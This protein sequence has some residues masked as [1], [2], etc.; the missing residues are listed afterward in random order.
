MEPQRLPSATH[1]PAGRPWDDA[2]FGAVGAGVALLDAAG[3]FARANRAFEELTGLSSADLEGSAAPFAFWWPDD[4]E[5]WERAIGSA[6]AG[7]CVT[8]HARIRAG[9]ATPVGVHVTAAPIAPGDGGPAAVVVTLV[10]L[11]TEAS[12]HQAIGDFTALVE[13]SPDAIVRFGRD[14][15]ISYMNRAAERNSGVPRESVVGVPLEA[16][17]ARDARYEECVEDVVRTGRPGEAEFLYH[18]VTGHEMWVRTRFLPEF[19]G[20]GGVRGVVTLAQNVTARKRVELELE[21]LLELNT[22]GVR[23]EAAI[24]G[25]AEMVA[26]GDDFTRVCEAV[27]RQVVELL[28]ADQAWVSRYEDDGEDFVGGSAADV[29]SAV[30]PGEPVEV[31]VNVEGAPWGVLRATVGDGITPEARDVLRTLADLVAT[32]CVNARTL[33]ELARIAHSDPLTGLPNRRAFF[34]HLEAEIERAHRFGDEL[35]LAMIDLDH[36]KQ[37]ND[38]FGHQRGDD[39][40]CHIG[41]RLRTTVRRGEVLARIGGEEFAWVLPRVDRDAALG[42]LERARQAVAAEPVEG[43]GVITVSAGVASLRPGDTSKSLMGRADDALYRAKEAGR[44][45]VVTEQPAS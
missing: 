18:S 35:T 45:R 21:R 23:R 10:P 22:R 14:G 5:R 25:I 32:A 11:P 12:N 1:V 9:Q 43:V 13:D 20:V 40:L 33:G 15:R 41:A 7:R 34:E 28:G 44:D 2:L 38:R 27:S 39:A 42:V 16:L 4:I 26:G 6:A 36:F 30:S 37:V 29:G 31:P 19:D 17:P 8:L 24:R 3:R